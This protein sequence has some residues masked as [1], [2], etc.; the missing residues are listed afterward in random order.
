MIITKPSDNQSLE[1]EIQRMNVE[2]AGLALQ[3]AILCANAFFGLVGALL[4]GIG[5]NLVTADK[6]PAVAWVLL[7]LGAIISL[8]AALLPIGLPILIAKHSKRMN[9]A[10]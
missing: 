2:R 10:S 8:V 4:V 6:P 7:C 5:T 1:D 9:N 3:P